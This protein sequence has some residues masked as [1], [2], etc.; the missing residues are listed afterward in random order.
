MKNIVLLALLIPLLTSCI[1][2]NEEMNIG[3]A[4]K[5]VVKGMDE[6]QKDIQD[7]SKKDGYETYC[8]QPKEINVDLALSITKGSEGKKILGV[9]T[10]EILGFFTPIKLG[11]EAGDI[12][13]TNRITIKFHNAYFGTDQGQKDLAKSC[14]DYNKKVR[15]QREEAKAEAEA[16]AKAEK[17]K[18][19]KDSEKTAKKENKN[20]Q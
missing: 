20:D 5:E 3:A 8:L 9:K 4:L 2:L 15:K 14:S 12:Q 13:K 19:N 17:M 16:K 18:N 7:R 11:K 1:T 6:M 10:E